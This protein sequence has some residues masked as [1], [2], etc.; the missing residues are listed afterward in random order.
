[1]QES[2]S[3]PR[4]RDP[5][6]RLESD[7]VPQKPDDEYLKDGFVPAGIWP[8]DG[9]FSHLTAKEL[10]E[11][12]DAYDLDPNKEFKLKA[13]RIN[14]LNDKKK[15]VHASLFYDIDPV[16]GDIV[17]FGHI[18]E[19]SDEVVTFQ[20]RLRYTEEFLL[21][22][23]EVAERRSLLEK[24]LKYELVL[25]TTKLGEVFHLVDPEDI[26]VC[27]LHGFARTFEH[28]FK[29]L[30]RDVM[31]RPDDHHRATIISNADIYVRKLL[32]S[33]KTFVITIPEKKKECVLSSLGFDDY[34][35]ISHNFLSVLDILYPTAAEKAKPRW[36]DRVQLDAYHP[37]DHVYLDWVAIWT[38]YE[39]MFHQ[40]RYLAKFDTPRVEKFQDTGDEFGDIYF[41]MF[42]VLSPPPYIHHIVAGHIKDMILQWGS[43]AA[44]SQQSWE[45]FMG[46]IKRLMADKG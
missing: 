38:K 43:P 4:H 2:C 18:D 16:D 35:L 26:V 3:T 32:N 21:T 33:S 24:C 27:T 1:M 14:L 23:P 12:V 31:A 11:L 9:E 20:L 17:E 28:L 15:E 41:D 42:D 7:V 45:R 5:Y 25:Q 40:L 29:R 46:E 8:L 30:L 37:K 36:I 34:R 10:K 39:D 19:V 44:L 13:E 6:K 22:V